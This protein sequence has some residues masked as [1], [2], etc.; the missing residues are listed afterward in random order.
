M[1]YIVPTCPAMK[2]MT[3]A[4]PGPFGVANS[5]FASAEVRFVRLGYTPAI[6]AFRKYA[7]TDP[8]PFRR[9]QSA[10][11]MLP[12]FGIGAMTISEEPFPLWAST[13]PLRPNCVCH[14]GGKFIRKP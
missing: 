14:P 1:T 13:A 9:S 3:T 10:A 2:H 5:T 12:L 7:P 8:V 6:D 11:D 4:V